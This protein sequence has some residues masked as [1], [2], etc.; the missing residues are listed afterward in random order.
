MEEAFLD[1]YLPIGHVTYLK[2]TLKCRRQ[3]ESE[4]ATSFMTKIE[5]LCRQIDIKMKEEN[6]CIYVL[7]KIFYI[8]SIFR[9]MTSLLKVLVGN[10]SSHLK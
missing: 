3:G 4:L 10:L 7:R 1:Q 9:S 6:K 5:S 8:P 2:M